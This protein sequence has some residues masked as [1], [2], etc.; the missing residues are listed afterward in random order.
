VTERVGPDTVARIVA[1]PG[2]RDR[3]YYCPTCYG[4][5]I[6]L[7]GVPVVCPACRQPVSWLTDQEARMLWQATTLDPI[8]LEIESDVAEALVL[9][10][11]TDEQGQ[12]LRAIL[13]LARACRI[14]GA[15]LK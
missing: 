13:A 9:G 14:Q 5:W 8:L 2:P 10:H 12:A 15:G 11:L 6:Q 3:I 1:Q 4:C 7:Y